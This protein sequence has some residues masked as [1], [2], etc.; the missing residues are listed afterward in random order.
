[1]TSPDH[2]LVSGRL[3]NGAVASVHVGAVP[4]AGSGY[5]MEIYGREGTLVAS[6]ED[7][8][9]FCHTMRLQGARGSNT[10][11]ELPIPDRF[12]Y[13]PPDFPR[14][15]AYNVGQLYH[16]FAEAIR[17]RDT[18]APTFDHAAALHRL[19][20]TIKQASDS[21]RELGVT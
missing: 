4:W 16:L 13:V 10:L 1:V 15:D 5:R 11:E 7:T 3:E 21:G 20:D 8:P 2:V 12:R 17:G 18:H 19:I 6:G 9:Q 14:G